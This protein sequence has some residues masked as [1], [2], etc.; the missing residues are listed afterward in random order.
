MPVSKLAPRARRYSF[1]SRNSGR[2]LFVSYVPVTRNETSARSA[3]RFNSCQFAHL[4]DQRCSAHR[5]LQ[6]EYFTSSRSLTR[7]IIDRLMFTSFFPLSLLLFFFARLIYC[8]WNFMYGSRE[9]D[10]RRFW[11]FYFHKIIYRWEIYSQCPLIFPLPYLRSLT[12]TILS[13]IWY[14]KKIMQYKN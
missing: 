6:R 11:Y 14:V 9:K 7:E 1:G 12:F 4:R 5:A 10:A 3:H 2:P 8:S 13:N